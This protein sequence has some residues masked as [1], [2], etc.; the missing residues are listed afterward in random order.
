MSQI[1]IQ[2][3]IDGLVRVLL[4]KCAE[5]YDFIKKLLMDLGRGLF[6]IPYH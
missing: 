2:W 4:S 1:K 6:I 5:K 3:L